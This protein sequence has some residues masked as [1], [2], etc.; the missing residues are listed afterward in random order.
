MCAQ[1]ALKE[2]R[3]L[4]RQEDFRPL[5]SSA[6]GD[7][8]W[9]L[10]GE[11]YIA[12]ETHA[13]SQG[14]FTDVVGE[15]LSAPMELEGA[16]I[17]STRFGELKT[18]M[19]SRAELLPDGTPT[20]GFFD[21]DETLRLQVV[22]DTGT[23]NVKTQYTGKPLAAALSSARFFEVLV[24]TPGRLSFE[25]VELVEE[26]EPIPHRIEVGEL[27][28]SAPEPKLAEYR[29]R[30]MVLEGL[31][32]ILINTGVE[33]RYPADTSDEE[34]LNN[35]N[36]VLK[37]IRGGWVP[38][39]VAGFDADM[40]A[41]EVRSLLD[42]LRDKGEVLRAF[43]FD[44]PDESYRVFGKEVNLG[45]SRRYLAA[46]RLSTPQGKIEAWLAEGPEYA[47]AL[48]LSWEP[49]D[50]TLMHVFFDEW[51]KSNVHTIDR[52]L[53]E[54]EAAYG[55]SSQHFDQAW[56]RRERWAEGVPDGKRWFS[57]VQAR[58]ELTREP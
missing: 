23:I 48:K 38:L 53:R 16:L 56:R 49:V 43:M 37:A 1:L 33:I 4:S 50:D 2:E 8:D 31:Y 15:R 5:A 10:P 39:S 13:T 42:E 52:E 44:L 17:A 18:P 32:D 24:T 3:R 11:E 22:G 14:L 36:F 51:P 55:V 47:E 41:T 6:D 58:E 28:F 26:G 25:V 9:L 40:P 20:F 34:G 19:I 27:P 21:R 12:S 35:L 54:F 46:A 29:D 30:L 7:G 57:L 45:P